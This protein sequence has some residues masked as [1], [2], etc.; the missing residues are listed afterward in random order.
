MQWF[1]F[2]V[3]FLVTYFYTGIKKVDVL[4]EK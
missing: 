1:A 4:H 3:F 2:A